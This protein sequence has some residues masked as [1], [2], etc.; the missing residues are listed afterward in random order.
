MHNKNIS[1]A[2][3]LEY[4]NSSK[5]TLFKVPNMLYFSNVL[6][7]DNLKFVL[8]KI[9]NT[10]N[11]CTLAIRS[12]AA[13]E[14]SENNSIAGGYSSV[15]NVPAHDEKKII[16]AINSVIDS[17]K[18][19]RPLLLNDEVIIQEMLQNTNMSGVVFTYDLNTG[20]PY[21]VI[22]YDDKSGITNTVTSGSGEFANRTLYVHRHSID[23]LHSDR[24]K[25]LLKAVQELEYVLG[26]EF[27]DIEFALGDD[28]KTH[29]L[30][31]RKITTQTNW[32]RGVSKKVDVTLQGVQSFITEKFKRTV[33]V[34]G[35]TTALGQMPDWNPVEMI[36]RVPRTL[37]ASLYQKVITDDAWRIARAEMEY[38]V[39]A[40]EPLMVMLAGQPFIDTRLSFH[41]FIPNKIPPVI[42]EKLV[43]HWVKELIKKPEHHD[44]IEFE[45]AITCYSFDFDKKIE[46]LI[47]D[48]LTKEEK[49][50]FKKIHQE[51]TR[52]LIKGEN[53]GSISTSLDKIEQLQQ[54]QKNVSSIFALVEDCIRLGTIPFSILA[55]HGFIAK[56]ILL[57]LKQ[58]NIITRDEV[59][60]ILGSIQTV[61][62]ELVDDMY[63]LQVNKLSINDFLKKFGHLRP[64]TYDI[65]SLRYD[66]MNSLTTSASSYKPHQ[67]PKKFEF[68]KL[69]QQK[70]N[71][72]LKEHGFE[73]FEADNLLNY[74]NK[75]T[76]SREYSKF[77]FTHSVS[78]II[79]LIRKFAQ[80]NGLSRD[81][82]SH[83]PISLI[84]N[85]KTNSDEQTIE[86]RLRKYSEQEADKH[87]VNIAVRLPQI[88]S[89]QA[90]AH[91]VPFQ[92]SHANFITT[93]K[94]SAPSLMLYSNI[95]GVSMAG[96]IIII[97]GADPGFDWI[98]SQK[99][100]G[101][102][103]KYGGANSHMAIR[104]AEFGLPA[105]IGC[106]EQKFEQLLKSNHVHLDCSSGLIE[107]IN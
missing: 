75:A 22:N 70:I 2:K 52:A 27:L 43:N 76:I 3:M 54:K 47:G 17:Y 82:I 107:P 74:I 55:R 85:T 25:K 103:T 24:F 98:F 53:K 59:N 19:K 93:K 37:A 42:A 9:K 83:I 78:N 15:L 87:N 96:K 89:D 84:L 91:I 97:E 10:F 100:S 8:D 67:H 12:S 21:Y 5:V 30:Q 58:L 32:N 104:C 29:L 63:L 4:I 51:H 106:G 33:G 23:K 99:I 60:Q 102:I 68:T 88:I 49:L 64:G 62:S 48:I 79:E 56:T 39:P 28:L 94:I 66:Q 77:V 38:S 65:M 35:E 7:K 40:G 20:A 69:Q 61:A 16:E 105:A 31:V 50:L 34:Y 81:E 95:E 13:D 1:K 46:T 6:I 41:S 90:G 101:L 71:T 57:S 45:I 80:E 36:G 26:N 72:L 11:D 86:Q 73:D 44:K 18:K 14:D 92:V